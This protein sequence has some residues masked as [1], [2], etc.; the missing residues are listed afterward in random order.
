MQSELLSFSGPISG[1]CPT[2]FLFQHHESVSNMIRKR[3]CLERYFRLWKVWW[4]RYYLVA[5]KNRS[6]ASNLHILTT[7][8]SNWMNECWWMYKYME[9]LPPFTYLLEIYSTSLDVEIHEGKNI[10]TRTRNIVISLML[11]SRR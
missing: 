4:D 6:L 11:W 3:L 2:T 1:L 5:L 8:V 9:N 10:H 7:S